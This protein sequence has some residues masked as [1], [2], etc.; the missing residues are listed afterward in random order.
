MTDTTGNVG[1]RPTRADEARFWALVESAWESLG[2]EPAALR[3]ALVER[4]PGSGDTDLCTV[5]DWL[6]P[7]LDPFLDNLRDLCAQAS[8]QDLADLDRVV[9]RKLYEIDRS[10]I[11]EATDG[12]D[13]GFLYCR[14]FIVALGREFYE[15]VSADPAAAILD[16]ECERMCYF[17]AHLHRERFGG[18][19]DTGSGISRESAS[20]AAGWRD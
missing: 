3:R 7:F 11:H 15:A 8:S 17:F 9:E 5:G 1:R 12:S 4:T 10:D 19:P 2:A 18:W 16:A 13:D 14:G 20:N 6:D